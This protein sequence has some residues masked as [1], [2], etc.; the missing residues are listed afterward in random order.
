MY[1][2]VFG[3]AWI[4]GYYIEAIDVTNGMLLWDQVYYSETVGER[5]Y[6][7][8]PIVKGDN[9]ELLIHEEYS[10]FDT[11][12]K[13]IWFVASA[14]RLILDKRNGV[15]LIQHFLFQKIPMPEEFLFLS[16]W[17]YTSLL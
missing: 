17:P 5:R 6:A 11:F 15:I 12:F 4:G 1:N 2:I 9:L 7:N 10:K 13:P 14:R 3:P 16:L 8:R